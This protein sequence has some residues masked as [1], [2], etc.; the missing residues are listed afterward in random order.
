MEHEAIIEAGVTGQVITL[1]FFLLLAALTLPFVKKFK[2]PHSIFLVITGLAIGIFLN[3]FFEPS[4]HG[5]FSELAVNIL[6]FNLSAETIFF[7]FLPTLIFESAYNINTRELIK[8][9][10]SILILAIPALL[11]SIVFVG[12]TLHYFTGLSLLLALLIGAITAATDPVAVIAIFKELG[13]PKRLSLLVEGESLFNDAASVVMFT[14]ILSFIG[15]TSDISFAESF[16]SGAFKFFMTFFGGA[17]VGIIVAYIFSLLLGMIHKNASVEIILTTMLAYLS[18][19]ISEHYLHLSGVM[20][21]VTAG[22]FLGSFGRTKISLGAHEFMKHFWETMAFSANAILFISIGLLMAKY[23]SFELLKTYMPLFVVT[24]ISVNIARAASV[25]TLLPALSKFNLTEK[26]SKQYE[27]VIWWG[28]GLRGAIALALALSLINSKLT[29]KEEETVL[30]VTFA[31]VM[32]TLFVNAL[33][34]RKVINWLGLDKP[35]N[36][37]LYGEKMAVLHCKTV[38]KEKI[39]SMAKKTSHYPHVYNKVLKNYTIDEKAAKRSLTFFSKLTEKEKTNVL[40]RETLLVEKD[41][42]FHSFANK[43]LTGASMMGLQLEVE[44]ELDRVKTGSPLFIHRSQFGGPTWLENI[45]K[46]FNKFLHHSVHITKDLAMRYEKAKATIDAFE[47]VKTFLTEKEH[48]WKELKNDCEDL[49]NKYEK[50][51]ITAEEEI[52]DIAIHFPE[53]IDRI[54]ETLLFAYGLHAEDKELDRMKHLGQLPDTAFTGLKNHITKEFRKLKRSPLED[55][56]PSAE[57][58]LKN[59]SLEIFRHMDDDQIRTLASHL[60]TKD[61]L[62]DSLLMKEGEKGA[63]MFIISRG[64]V[65]V[66]KG[67]GANKK[68]LAILKNGDFVG[69]M[70]LISHEKRNATV[71]AL[72][73]GS[74]LCLKKSH[75]DEFMEENIELKEKLMEIYHAREE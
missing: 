3:N 30:L 33:S 60:R 8:D 10:P 4:S 39:E 7:I 48:D 66:Y 57:K 14:I 55:F 19:I 68:V 11:I 17:A 63:E 65:Q 23:L 13:A 62:A 71:K 42:Y 31:V 5:M 52:A 73:H 1:I 37:E 74:A 28:G 12:F 58:L 25:F 21:T 15:V 32:F 9:M 16:F 18:F 47:N 43:E 69:E 75:F 56:K 49:L 36:D 59:S 20:S 38:A 35:T 51:K 2:F 26:V 70:S 72:S 46:P 27:T 64:V 44:R 50:L 53:Y 24:I 45:L 29:L 54:V 67:E 22:L 6:G 34:I 41:A 40:I 61:F